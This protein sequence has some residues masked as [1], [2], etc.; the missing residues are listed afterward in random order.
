MYSPFPILIT[1]V[2][3]TLGPASY[4]DADI[5]AEWAGVAPPVQ[6]AAHSVTANAT[7]TSVHASDIENTQ[8]GTC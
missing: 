4:H 1:E 5:V 7:D 2:V 3:S 6:V 8:T